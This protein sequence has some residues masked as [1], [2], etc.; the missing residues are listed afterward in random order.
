MRPAS[1]VDSVEV[2]DLGS[3][4]MGASTYQG[5]R[6]WKAVRS[7]DVEGFAKASK[8]SSRKTWR[9]GRRLMTQV[10]QK[11]GQAGAGKLRLNDADASS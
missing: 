8:G 7:S 4:S 6:S 2:V 5:A 10:Y 11:L 1:L 9:G 3:Y